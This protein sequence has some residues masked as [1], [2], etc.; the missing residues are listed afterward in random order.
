MRGHGAGLGIW[1]VTE[2]TEVSVLPAHTLSISR[3]KT[4]VAA[5]R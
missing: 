2:P 4:H 3:R 5:S 1:M